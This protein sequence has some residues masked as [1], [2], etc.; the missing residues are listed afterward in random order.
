MTADRVGT[1]AY[2]VKVLVTGA[3]GFIGSALMNRL[4]NEGIDVFGAIRGEET[5]SRLLESPSLGQDADWRPLLRTRTIVVHT[6]GRAH[7]FDE[8]GPDAVELFRSINTW[9]TIRLAEQAA[10]AGVRRFVFLSS[11]GVNGNRTTGHPF[12]EEQAPAPQEPY[13]VSKMEAEQALWEIAR[14]SGMEVVILRPPLVYGPGAPGNFG[15]LLAAVGRGL[16]LP[17]GAVDANRRTFVGLDNLIDMISTC[18]IHPAAANQLFLAGDAESLST[19]DLLRRLAAVL[20]RRAR[21]FNVP[22]WLLSSLAAPLGKKAVID[23]LCDSLEVDISKA[24]N[25]LGWSPSLTV[26]ESLARIVR[27]PCRRSAA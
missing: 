15:R 17:L 5:S 18:I 7:V 23:R 20:G 19:A 16:P 8:G 9:G 12:T 4:F 14:S 26:N 25:M 22:T 21:L 11:I 10:E 27:Q 13:A 2:P 1:S 3:S 24:K 6:A